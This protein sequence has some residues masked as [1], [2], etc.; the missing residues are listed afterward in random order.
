MFRASVILAAAF[1]LF[2]AFSKNRR[3]PHFLRI[4]LPFLKNKH[5]IF[6][7]RVG[8]VKK[9]LQNLLKSNEKELF[10]YILHKNIKNIN[11][12]I[13]KNNTCKINDVMVKL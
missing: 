5:K 7:K 4:F 8:R 1:G 6:E 10:L 13:Y 11:E 9:Y 12:K 3:F 2:F